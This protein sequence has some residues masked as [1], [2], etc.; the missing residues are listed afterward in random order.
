MRPG[1]DLLRS[2]PFFSSCSEA[3]LAALNDIGDLAR[4]GPDDILYSEGDTVAE[5]NVLTA[6]YV[7]ATRL[8]PNGS[9]VL[10]DVI[11]PVRP[12]SLPVALLG[13]PA[14]AGMRMLTAGRLIVFEVAGLWAMLDRYPALER[15]LFELALK[16]LRDLEVAA[17]DLKLQSAPRRLAKYLLSLVKE[18]D[19]TPV[20][21]VLPFEKR[22]LAA[23]IGCSQEN[24]SRAF[25]ALR[26]LG[27]ETQRGIIVLR[28]ILRLY[29]FV[30]IERP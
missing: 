2:V 19:A 13:K 25:A 26:P 23:H 16:E 14:P 17:Y 29:S 7:G 18:H 28:D 15:R 5:I 9:V 12:L 1:L 27:V 22:L 20:R 21:F 3:E 8:N 11:L 10:A 24:L 4:V 30:G 6:G